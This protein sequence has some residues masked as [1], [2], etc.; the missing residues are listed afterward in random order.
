MRL[1]NDLGLEQIAATFTV[2]LNNDVGLE[3][4]AVTFTVQL[5]NDLVLE[6]VELGLEQVESRAR[7]S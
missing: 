3:Q 5:N 4:V 7:T 1:N 2:Q 6:Q